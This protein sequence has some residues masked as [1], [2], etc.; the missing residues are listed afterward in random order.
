[1]LLDYAGNVERAVSLGVVPRIVNFWAIGFRV[2]AAFRTDFSN[3]LEHPLHGPAKAA[4]MVGS[5]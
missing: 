5:S 4:Q 3:K 2:K 1:M